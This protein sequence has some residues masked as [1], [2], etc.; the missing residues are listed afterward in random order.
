MVYSLF[1]CDYFHPTTF[2]GVAIFAKVG[3]FLCY[4]DAKRNETSSFATRSN[5][6][7]SRLCTQRGH[8]IL[9]KKVSDD[10]LSK[11]PRRFYSS[12]LRSAGGCLITMGAPFQPHDEIEE[13]LKSD[14]YCSAKTL[15]PSL[16]YGSCDCSVACS[17]LA[18]TLWSP[19]GLT[20][21]LYCCSVS[22]K[23]LKSTR[24]AVLPK[25]KRHHVLVGR[26]VFGN[27]HGVQCPDQ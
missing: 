20:S 1:Q 17:D 9:S 18:K 5:R 8:R 10:F 21:P 23:Y 14:K 6:T 12:L 13:L 2:V 4:L 11:S 16:T 24:S 25:L 7:R 26:C 27:L 19:L 15:K 3:F 22:R